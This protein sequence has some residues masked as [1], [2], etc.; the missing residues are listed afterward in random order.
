MKGKNN[1]NCKKKGKNNLNC[2][3]LFSCSTLTYIQG[4]LLIQ[5]YHDIQE[6]NIVKG[7]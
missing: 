4:L 6:N 3:K 2:K 7:R 5:S 1:S